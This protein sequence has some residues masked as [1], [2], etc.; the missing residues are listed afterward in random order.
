MGQANKSFTKQVHVKAAEFRRQA[1]ELRKQGYTYA[2]ISEGLRAKGINRTPQAV[3]KAVKKAIAD[4]TREPAEE[5]LV[6]ELERL[7][8]LLIPAIRQARNGH[9]GAIGIVLK[10][11]DRRA[12]Y[13]GLDFT[14]G[15]ESSQLT[16]EEI[17]ELMQQFSSFLPPAPGSDS[18]PDNEGENTG[19]DGE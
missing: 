12:R 3:E 5:V 7:D 4:I 14:P 2:K 16:V 8:E 1:L 18:A 6:L 15:K 17:Q 9:L 13:L 10:L 11:M 19:E